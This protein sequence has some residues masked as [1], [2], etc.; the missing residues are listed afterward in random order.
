MI[1]HIVVMG[2]SGAGKT[3]LARALAV[4]LGWPFVEGDALHPPGNIA[5]M[6]AGIPLS[7][8]DRLPFLENVAAVLAS[9]EAV[10]VSCSA[11][12][13]RYRDLIRARA[14]GVCFVLPLLDRAE[15]KARLRM[16][17]GHFMPPALLD[18]QLAALEM[19]DVDEHAILIDGTPGVETQV[20]RVLSSLG[21]CGPATA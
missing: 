21:H 15:L 16:R 13:R 6:A 11:L 1:R 19:P 12:K 18:S 2:V 8:E 4:R 9:E 3:T 10:V 5:K 17:S 20:A 14:G 7:D